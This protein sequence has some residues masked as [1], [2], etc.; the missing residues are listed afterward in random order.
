MANYYGTTV[1]DGGKV[2]PE[3]VEKVRAIIAKWS[4]MGSEGEISAEVSD[5]GELAVW[6]FD[7]FYIYDTEDEDSYDDLTEHYL[8]ELCPFIVEP[9]IIKSVG[10]EKCR[11]VG[12][13]AWIVHQNG[14]EY[15]SL[16]DAITAKLNS[17]T[18]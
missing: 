4:R 2:A 7:D 14:V 6:G 17:V 12:A 9:L 3:N 13:G 5:S 15:A 16:D 1:T 10:N 18:K 8:K 11:Y